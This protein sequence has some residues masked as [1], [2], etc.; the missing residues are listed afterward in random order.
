MGSKWRPAT[1]SG[2][3]AA[4]PLPTDPARPFALS[5]ATAVVG[6]TFLN[7]ARRFPYT[8]AAVLAR[9]LGVDLETIAALIAVSQGASLL[10]PVLGPLA[11]R[12]GHRPAMLAGLLL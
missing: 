7:T 1:S 9:G 2:I 5:L 8:Y 11:D 12:W 6:R 4:M 3:I 10:A